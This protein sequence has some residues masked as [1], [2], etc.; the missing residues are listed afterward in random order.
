MATY[1]VQRGVEGVCASFRVCDTRGASVGSCDQFLTELSQR[2]CSIY[3]Q[4]AY[5]IGLAH[6]F[7]WLHNA[8]SDPDHV[9]RQTVGSY[10]AEFARGSRQGAI[11]SSR[12]DKVRQP[13]TV[14]HR[15]ACFVHILITAFAVTRKMAAARGTAV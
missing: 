4:R 9:T 2:D 15:S 5:A 10:I 11:T 7:N 13:R 6:F 1:S 12:T 8:G 3:T 14:N